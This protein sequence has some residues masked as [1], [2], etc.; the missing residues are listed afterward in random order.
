MKIEIIQNDKKKIR[1][2]V[3][4]LADRAERVTTCV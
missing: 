3:L 1:D 4:A 2:G